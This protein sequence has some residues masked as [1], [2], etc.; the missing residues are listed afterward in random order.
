V[1]A[2]VRDLVVAAKREDPRLQFDVLAPAYR[3]ETEAFV[4]RSAFDEHRFRYFAPARAQTLAGPGIV[5]MIEANRALLAVVPFLFTFE[6]VAMVRQ[7]RRRRPDVIW[8]HWFTPQ[9]VNAALASMITG[10]PWVL[11]SHANDV[12]IWRKAPVIGPRLV[13]ALLPRATRI[14]AVSAQTRRKMESFFTPAEWQ[15]LL[16]RIAT[17]PMGVHTS[18]LEEAPVHDAEGDRVITFVGRLAEKKGAALLLD[19]FSL[20]A[21]RADLADVRLVI[22]GDGPLRDELAARVV[23]LGIGDRVQ[24]IGYVSGEHK[25][26]VLEAATVIAVPSIETRSG[27]SEGFPVVVKAALAA[28]KPCVAS[29]ATGADL[30]VDGVNGFVVPAGD[31]SALA[32]ALARALALPHG[33]RAAMATAARQSAAALDWA[34]IARRHIAHLF[35]EPLE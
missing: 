12:R 29:D 23:T 18:N 22:A 9:G 17:I 15:Q 19:A 6:L 7:I 30:L 2:F 10:V 14:T 1:P 8:A 28:G 31:T 25:Q 26:A 16:P 24:M 33:A 32:A 4:S 21:R 20:L 11:T 3:D 13:R 27:D 5:P 35:R 34:P